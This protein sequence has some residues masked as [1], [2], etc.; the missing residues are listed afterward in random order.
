MSGTGNESGPSFSLLLLYDLDR[1]F[2]A[3]TLRESCVLT[4]DCTREQDRGCS[5]LANKVPA[6]GAQAL[7][8]RDLV[9]VPVT[10]LSLYVSQILSA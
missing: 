4:F 2:S 10:S 6:E 3:V 9:R 5:S 1:C 7:S 8:Q